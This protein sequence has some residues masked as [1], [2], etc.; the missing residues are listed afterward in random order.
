MMEGRPMN[1]LRF[2]CCAIAL[3]TAIAVSPVSVAFAEDHAPSAGH[4]SSSLSHV[5]GKA[6]NV[7]QPDTTPEAAEAAEEAHAEAAAG[8]DAHE[9][10]P[11]FPQLNI[12]TYPSQVFWLFVSFILLYVLMSKLAL[13]RVASVIDTRDAKKDADLARAAEMSAEAEKLKTSYAST[14][15]KAQE[16]AAS[17]ISSAEQ[18]IAEK[19]ASADAAFADHAKKRL[20]TAEQAVNKAKQEALNAMPD[21]AAEIAADMANKIANVGIAKADAK[22]T[23]TAVMQKGE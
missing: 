23:V 10:S 22:K 15:A 4:H 9:A 11:G 17:A 8:H 2:S 13:P 19:I 14:L 20:L 16:D 7:A 3:A 6:V 18:A 5:E 21:I 1:M 12:S